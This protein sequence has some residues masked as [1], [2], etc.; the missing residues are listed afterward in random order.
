MFVNVPCHSIEVMVYLQNSENY[1]TETK[2][3]YS[4]IWSNSAYASYRERLYLVQNKAFCQIKD[5]I[6]PIKT[7]CFTI[8]K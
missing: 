4:F 6:L 8:Q 5:N 1:Q 3:R 2:Q 7:G